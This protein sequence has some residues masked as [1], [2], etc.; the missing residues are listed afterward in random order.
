MRLFA[1]P[2]RPATVICGVGTL[3]LATVAGAR[4]SRSRIT[5]A[6][7]G[8]VTWSDMVRRDAEVRRLAAR[9]R[10][11]A[12][13]PLPLLRLH[14]ASQLPAQL[15]PP[16][17]AR[18]RSLV[19]PRVLGVATSFRA[20]EDDGTRIP[21]DTMGAV[22]PDHLLTML[23]S[24]VRIQDRRGSTISTVSLDTFWTAGTGL[25]G[26]PFDPHVVYDARSGR[27]IATV[28]ADDH[29]TT[30]QI[31][32]AVSETD[33]PT[34]GWVFHG[35]PADPAER[36]WADFPALGVNDTWIVITNLMFTLADDTVPFVGTRMLVLD[37][38][39]A[40]EGGEV[41]ITDFAPGFDVFDFGTSVYQ[42]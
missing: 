30:S 37:K 20:L 26:A 36:T 23:N 5:L 13:I 7:A 33:D 31:W 16:S 10:A 4:A 34:G 38:T 8:V 9:Y 22:G 6:P 39:T 42:G 24:Q 2:A 28:D 27:W 40:L 21:P 18:E 14:A 3:L 17:I 19:A 1:T 29:Q 35:L 15:D 25:V 12:R 41:S 11:V 32:F